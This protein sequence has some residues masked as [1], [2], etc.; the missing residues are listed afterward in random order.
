MPPASVCSQAQHPPLKAVRHL[1][2]SMA[3]EKVEQPLMAIEK[4]EQPL[5]SKGGLF[6]Y[7]ALAHLL[8]QKS[9]AVYRT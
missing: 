2:A 5:F 6:H 3:I 7:L 9:L 4:V 1:L 8:A